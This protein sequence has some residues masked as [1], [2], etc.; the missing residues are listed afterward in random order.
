MWFAAAWY[1][2]ADPGGM[3]ALTLQKLLGLGSYQT[4]WTMLRRY[5]T[6]MVLPDR[7]VLH[8]RVEVD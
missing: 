1:M 4:A 8:G 6:A 7:D 2:T 5:R 3:A